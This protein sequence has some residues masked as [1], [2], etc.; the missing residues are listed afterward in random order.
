V[1]DY[2]G[3]RRDLRLL[4]KDSCTE[5]MLAQCTSL[6]D[7]EPIREVVAGGHQSARALVL[8]DFLRSVVDYSSDANA[9]AAGA[10]IGIEA[11]GRAK[12]LRRHPAAEILNVSARTVRRNEAA[13]LQSLLTAITDFTRDTKAKNRFV[14]ENQRWLKS[15][16]AAVGMKPT[17][18]EQ[19]QDGS[20]EAPP[21]PEPA[22][23]ISFILRSLFDAAE[24]DPVAR[25]LLTQIKTI[26]TADQ[27]WLERLESLTG[28]QSKASDLREYLLKT[29]RSRRDERA[30]PG[31]RGLST[32]IEWAEVMIGHAK[33]QG[34]HVQLSILMGWQ[35]GYRWLSGDSQIEQD[36]RESLGD[37]YR[38]API[39]FDNDENWLQKLLAPPE[40]GRE[41][42]SMMRGRSMAYMPL[43]EEAERDWRLFF[44]SCQCETDEEPDERCPV[45]ALIQA[46]TRCANS[47]EAVA[48][49]NL[50]IPD[51]PGRHV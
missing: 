32:H 7:L 5:A 25:I 39:R 34:P 23:D 36:A 12:E 15:R 9:K 1:W 3:M 40:P 21:A 8:R 30:R 20:A 22:P 41:I 43:N 27:L 38:H 45:H 31:S 10:L 2:E 50:A 51:E 49:T 6:L 37:L 18:G 19:T 44:E 17:D 28:L 16:S 33:L 48:L 47:A 11:A 42:E 29:V 35:E 14:Y 13:L 4:A 46:C 26:R 24:S